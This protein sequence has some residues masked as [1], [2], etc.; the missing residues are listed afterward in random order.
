MDKMGADFL[1][2]L[3]SIDKRLG[4]NAKPIQW[5]I[6]AEDDFNGVIDLLEMKAYQFDGKEEEN[7]IEIDIPEHLKDL[8]EERRID[9]IET[10]AEFDENLWKL[11]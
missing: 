8:C 7:H 2:S 11:S 9:L 10:I 6:G 1:Y 5:P 3:D 4:V